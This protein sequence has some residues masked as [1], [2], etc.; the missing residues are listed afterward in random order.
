[1]AG[2][3]ERSMPNHSL[4]LDPSKRVREVKTGV[5][6]IFSTAAATPAIIS[7]PP[8]GLSQK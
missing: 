8:P 7:S 5:S 1:M 6:P 3:L 2:Y 4:Y